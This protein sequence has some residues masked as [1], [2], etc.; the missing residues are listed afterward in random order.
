M[1][2]MFNSKKCNLY[3]I[4]LVIFIFVVSG[5]LFFMYFKSQKK[6]K[7]DLRLDLVLEKTNLYSNESL[8][9]SA[10]LYYNKKCDGVFHYEIF[11]LSDVSVVI[12]ES[13]DIR[14]NGDDSRAKSLALSR[15]LPG[16]HI[17]RAKLKC[18]DKVEISIARFSIL[19]SGEIASSSK[20]FD[21]QT[22]KGSI[23][24]TKTE[25]SKILEIIDSSEQNQ[26]Q[27]L[28]MC[29]SL[30]TSS[31][32]KCYSGIAEKTK[33]KEYCAKIQDITTRDGCY[34]SLAL[35]G[36]YGACEHIVDSYQR[37]ACNSL[38]ANQG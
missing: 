18:G 35:E 21:E 23:E 15:L 36:V 17:L 5:I 16:E 12:S 11:R 19:Q 14:L 9:F 37:E 6:E 33:N 26:N 38:K 20:I 1:A 4:A 29:D 28:Q 34:A 7:D 24:I 8:D 32:D 13:E 30:D 2:G 31:K 3:L 27:A 10:S 25:E 22:A